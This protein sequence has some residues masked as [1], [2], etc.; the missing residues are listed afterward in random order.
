MKG[1]Q[2]KVKTR[3]TVSHG[4]SHRGVLR[5]C[6]LLVYKAIMAVSHVTSHRGVFRVFSLLVSKVVQADMVVYLPIVYIYTWP[7]VVR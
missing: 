7:H 2:F 4:T 5:V 3:L 1:G 6:S